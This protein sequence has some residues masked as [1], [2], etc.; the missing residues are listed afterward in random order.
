MRAL[1][2][3]CN[4][5][6]Q[7]TTRSARLHS[8]ALVVRARHRFAGAHT[9]H[10]VEQAQKRQ[11]A[12]RAVQSRDGR[13]Q[14][15]RVR[16]DA[17]RHGR[18]AARC[19]GEACHGKRAAGPHDVAVEAVAPDVAEE[20]ARLHAV[21][22]FGERREVGDHAAAVAAEAQHVGAVHGT[23]RSLGETRGRTRRRPQCR[24][25]GSTSTCP[26]PRRGRRQPRPQRRS[27]PSSKGMPCMALTWG[28]NISSIA[29]ARLM[30]RVAM[31]GPL[32]SGWREGVA[33]CAGLPSGGVPGA[34][35]RVACRRVGMRR[36]ARAPV[37]RRGSH[38]FS[39]KTLRWRGKR[40]LFPVPVNMLA[41]ANSKGAFRETQAAPIRCARA[42]C[43]PASA[44]A[45][46]VR[47]AL[48]QRRLDP[49][50]SVAILV[51]LNAIAF[52]PNTMGA[53]FVMVG[54]CAVVCVWCGRGGFGCA[55]VRGVRGGHGRRLPV[56]ARAQ[57]G[58]GIVRSHSCG[59]ALRVLHR[60]V[61][62]EHDRHHARGRAGV[63]AAARLPAAPRHHRAVRGAAV[64]PHDDSRVRLSGGGYACAWRAAWRSHGDDASRARD[65]GPACACDEPPCHRGRRAGQRRHRARHG[66]VAS[67]HIVLRPAVAR[68][69]LDHAG[70]VFGGGRVFAGRAD[71]LV[72]RV[73]AR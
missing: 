57:F 16:P 24:P 7:S 27:S 69:G 48:A 10:L 40:L 51:L 11:V 37:F 31:A 44:P 1:P 19:E 72:V 46:R 13:G 65:G 68:D 59:G 42:A 52:S 41:M 38:P 60:H 29:V 56:A 5:P 20:R 70:G 12:V 34:A 22:H 3:R 53:H 32:L 62:L 54:L 9:P 2:L 28:A 66:L 18:R 6:H 61:R 64:L 8:L 35:F 33:G 71:G 36:A 63:R 55:L 45:V 47:G 67:A 23:C 21:V 14:R 58:V 4:E 17:R 50:V 26:G 73:S 49:R 25:G 43:A 15:E 39:A 30:P